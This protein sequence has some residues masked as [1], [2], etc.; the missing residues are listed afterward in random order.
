MCTLATAVTIGVCHGS[1]AV[2]K[3]CRALR[4][5]DVVGEVGVGMENIPALTAAA[6]ARRKNKGLQ[7]ILKEYS[8][9]GLKK[10]L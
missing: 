4:S 2:S 1:L 9:Y 8:N 6:A 7:N 10:K 3:L 5:K